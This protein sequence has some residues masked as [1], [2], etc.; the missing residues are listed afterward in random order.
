MK[1]GMDE[2]V[3]LH[4][5]VGFYDGRPDEVTMLVAFDLDTAAV[6]VDRATLLFSRSDQT[7]NSFLGGR[8]N[9]GA[10]ED[11]EAHENE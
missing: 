8:R 10:T 11:I 2:L 3:A 9:D 5:G 6:Q 1:R 4:V 7:K